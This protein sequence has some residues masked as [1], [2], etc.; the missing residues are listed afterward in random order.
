MTHKKMLE[1]LY[2]LYLSKPFDKEYFSDKLVAFDCLMHE[3]PFEAP[4]DACLLYQ[5]LEEIDI[6]IISLQEDLFCHPYSKSIEH[7]N[8]KNQISHLTCLFDK[9]DYKLRDML[10]DSL[11]QRHIQPSYSYDM[12][13]GWFFAGV[14][15]TA[16]T[17]NKVLY[18]GRIVRKYKATAKITL[19]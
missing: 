15:D 12:L 9:L 19:H 13:E 6:N 11:T 5:G 8:L 3:K 10:S 4:R 14:K 1:E 16:L 7:I 17:S 18:T 2:S